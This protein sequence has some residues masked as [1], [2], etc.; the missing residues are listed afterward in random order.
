MKAVRNGGMRR[1]LFLGLMAVAGL[2]VILLVEGLYLARREDET[3]AELEHAAA[4][5][6]DSL[7]D[8]VEARLLIVRNLQAFMLASETMPDDEAFDAYAAAVLDHAPAIRTLQ[9]VNTDLIIEHTYPLAGNEAALGLDV[10]SRP[11]AVDVE[12]T[13]AER[14]LTVD[15]PIPLVQGPLGIVARLPLYRDEQFLGLVQIAIEVDALLADVTRGPGRRF[16][17][18]L[19]DQDQDIFWGPAEMMGMTRTRRLQVGDDLWT[20]T[21]GWRGGEPPAD[22]LPRLFIWGLGLSLL[23]NVL[24]LANRT[25]R[26][27]GRL[28]AAVEERTR[29][30]RQSETR[31]RT[32][33]EEASDMIAI[34]DASGRFLD[35]NPR[36]ERMLAYTVEELRS[37]TLEDVLTR[38]EQEERPLSLQELRSGDEVTFHRWVRP[39]SGSGGQDIAVE[40]NVRALEGGRLLAVIRDITER[41]TAEIALR[42]REAILGAVGFSAEKFLREGAWREQIE[43]VLAE[44]GTAAAVSR[45]YIFEN[46]RAADGTLVTSQRYEWVTSG[47]VPQ[48]EMLQDLRYDELGFERWEE[49]LSQGGV[50]QGDVESLPAG[51]RA[52]LEA[53]NVRSIAVVPIFVGQQWWGFMGFD[54]CD[55][56]RK[57]SESEVRALEAAAS[58]L[59]AAIAR[60]RY[61]EEIRQNAARAEALVRTA[62]RLNEP[63]DEQTVLETICEE[64]ARVLD[65][66][67]AAIGLYDEEREVL[68]PKADVGYPAAFR[69]ELEPVPISLFYRLFGDAD[70]PVVLPDIREIDL[71]PFSSQV[72][73]YDLRSVAFVDVTHRGQ[74]LGALTVNSYGEE[75]TFGDDELALLTGLA[76]QAAQAIANARL[77]GETR[78]LLERTR[79]QSRQVKQIMEVVPEGVVLLNAGNR[80]VMANPT[81]REYLSLLSGV[82]VG[83]RLETIDGQPL[84]AV[85][86]PTEGEMPWHELEQDEIN[87]I[88]MLTQRTVGTSGGTAGWVLVIRE[89]TEERLR[90][91]HMQ[92]QE[93]LATVGQLAAGIA[94][95]FNN[96]MAI[97]TLYSQSL[98][99]DP[100]FP[101]RQQYLA[102]ISKQARHAANLIS[103]IL[104]FSRRAVMER[105]QLDLTPFVKEVIRLLERT[106]PENI[107]LEHETGRDS[108]VV[109]AD[110]TRLQQALMNLALNARDA[111]PDGGVLKM[112]LDRLNLTEWERPPVPDMAAGE[113]VRLRVSDTG[114]GI[115]AE[116]FD[117]IFEPFFTTKQPG[118]G[119]GLGLAQVYGIVKQHGGEISVDSAL[120]VGTT[121]TLYLPALDAPSEAPPG[122]EEVLAAPAGARRT[123]LLV[124]DS[125]ATRIAIEDTLDML[126]YRVLAASTGREALALFSRHEEEID[127]VLSDM[128]MPEMGGVEL[129]QTLTQENPDLIMIVMTGYPL[130]DEGRSLLQEGIVDWI[131]KPFSPQAIAGKLRHLLE[132]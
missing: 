131:H 46:G 45:V 105:G 37:M 92:R 33:V 30:L 123:I 71:E 73:K 127:V 1:W 28:E 84:E 107:A 60:E 26:R 5:A 82:S 34:V 91:K 14:R 35:V 64:A 42:R 122:D 125:E 49:I 65:V 119:T 6:E 20:L 54:D 116:N 19:R 130:A 128:V 103:Q 74:L 21:V 10:M 102:T 48:M 16:E 67:A 100:D 88:F 9:Y 81:G 2:A 59:G 117:H 36:G 62:A 108:Y 56:P 15:D 57:W 7:T 80:V 70:G 85:L 77:L 47:I 32:L 97:I 25:W 101:K 61:E 41:K 121:F 12:E 110:P 78:R 115:P 79:E 75:R 43:Q 93:R 112:S 104:D 132:A 68:I 99:R 58:T 106:L 27:A 40:A 66:P 89:V 111:M 50:V 22:L 8:A 4:I 31:Y 11:A 83:E 18:Q 17:I 38:G 98:E 39:K 118:V 13:I 96:I 69:Q 95:D 3:S 90:Q 23:F 86:V 87:R 24:L 129:Y 44:L 55:Q 63:V 29:Q 52:L 124:E 113:W 76:S 94:H 51:E 72:A 53:Q 120:N 126:G 109:N 114:Y